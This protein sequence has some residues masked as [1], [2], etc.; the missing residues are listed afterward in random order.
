MGF[1]P[2]LEG[3]GDSILALLWEQIRRVKNI[4]SK[5]LSKR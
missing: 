5:A 3:E 4:F 1:G 2:S